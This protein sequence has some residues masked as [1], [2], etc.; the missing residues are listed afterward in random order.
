MIPPIVGL[1]LM[2]TLETLP[3]FSARFSPEMATWA[4]Q[5]F[6]SSHLIGARIAFQEAMDLRP[7]SSG[8]SSNHILFKA[9]GRNALDFDCV[10]VI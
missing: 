1:V 6:V 7:A 9:L 4:A 5:L 3:S 8:V 2:V 10:S